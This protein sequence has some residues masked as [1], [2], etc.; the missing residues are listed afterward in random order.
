MKKIRLKFL[1]LMIA[2]VGLILIPSLA[3][4]ASEAP[5]NTLFL[6]GQFL[7][8]AK[9]MP[10]PRFAKTVILMVHHDRTGAQGFVI[11]KVIGK[12]ALAKFLQGFGV[13]SQAKPETVGLYYGG[14]VEFDRVAVLHSPDYR[15]AS[16]K[17]ISKNL[18]WSDRKDVLTAIANGKGPQKRM[19]IFGY[20]G[21]APGQLEHEMAQETWLTAPADA[22]LIFDKDPK[23]LWD[24]I[25][26]KAGLKL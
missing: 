6:K 4:R 21:W 18:A 7:V 17:K 19:F 9:K 15:D 3:G 24:R 26:A 2:V 14:P 8:A 25:L 1:I 10:D 12:G 23:T 13:K 16:T 22:D 20:S 5:K 11:N